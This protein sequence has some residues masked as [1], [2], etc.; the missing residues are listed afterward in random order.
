MAKDDPHFRLRIP[1]D[2]KARIEQSAKSNRRSANAEIIQALEQVYPPDPSVEDVLERVHAAIAMSE[3]VAFPYRKVLIDALDDLSARLSA[4][5]EFGQFRARTLP[6]EY[7]RATDHA[8]RWTRW[9]RAKRHGVEQADLER[10]L[11]KGMLHKLGED[12]IR[13][14]I[15]LFKTKQPERALK[16]LRLDEIVFAKPDA[17]LNAIETDLRAFYADNWGDPDEAWERETLPLDD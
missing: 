16:L 1:A 15:R 6:D 4:G 10:E 2:L 3:T 17:A 9:R 5:L 8:E 12:R 7:Q 13:S 14:A 11:A